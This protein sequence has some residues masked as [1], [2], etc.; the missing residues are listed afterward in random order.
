MSSIYDFNI[1][2]APLHCAQIDLSPYARWSPN[3]ITVSGGHGQGSEL[4]Q[5]NHPYG[6]YVDDNK[7]I[8]VADYENHR[9]VAWPP[10]ATYGQVVAGGNGPGQGLHQLNKPT[11]VII[12]HATESLLICDCLNRRV[13]RWPLR[14][15][16]RGEIL[17]RDINCRGLTMDDCGFLYVS[18]V[19]KHEVRRWQVGK[20]RGTVVAGGNGQG[21]RLNQLN[22]PTYLFVD[23]NYTI[24]VSD[25]CNHR[26]VKWIKGITE[27]IVVAGGHGQGENVNQMSHPQGVIVDEVDTVYVADS[28]NYRIMRWPR[29]AT[30]GTV[31]AGGNDA[32]PQTNQLNLLE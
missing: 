7:I 23:R 24:Y 8:Y 6:L 11:D 2:A 28:W 27:G 21:L 25:S 14:G 10:G 12:D 13:V 3:G 5:L 17:L 18:D 4:S 19:R 15:G 26:V 22:F 32:G 31:V 1:L 29:G 20:A 16:I 30:Q 9:I